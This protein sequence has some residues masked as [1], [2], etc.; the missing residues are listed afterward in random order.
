MIFAN[1]T[2]RALLLLHFGVFMGC[3]PQSKEMVAH[4][5]SQA[6]SAHHSL[7]VTVSG[8]GHATLMGSTVVSNERFTA[9]LVESLQKTGLFQSVE[10]SGSAS[11]SLNA[12]TSRIF[13]K[14]P[15]VRRRFSV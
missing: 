2:I 8:G 6:Q 12:R 1:K 5:L 7:I 4:K 11:Y 9:A 10:T 3:A 15:K 14:R 13:H